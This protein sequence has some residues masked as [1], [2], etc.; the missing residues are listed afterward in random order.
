MV[1]AIE[2]AAAILFLIL[3]P[4]KG[5]NVMWGYSATRLA[6]IALALF[7]LG[8]LTFLLYWSREHENEILDRLKLS[9]SLVL[10]L[11]IIVI[12]LLAGMGIIALQG[13]W[14]RFGNIGSYIGR[15]LPL[16]FWFA[17]MAWQLQIWMILNGISTKWD[18]ET[19]VSF[20]LTA[21]VIVFVLMDAILR[22]N[23]INP[24]EFNRFSQV[25]LAPNM[26]GI[27]LLVIASFVL[28]IAGQ[29]PDKKY[30][31]LVGR[32]IT[33]FIVA[34][35]IFQF[36]G[37]VGKWYLRQPA[38]AYFP[39]L[40]D[41]FLHGKLYL[42][43]PAITMELTQKDNHWYVPYPPLNALLMMPMVALWG[44][45]HVN[46]SNYSIL[47]AALGV[48][49]VFLILEKF[50]EHGW[51]QL[52]TSAN[53]WLT[54]LFGLSTPFW[55]IAIS[56]EVWY[57]N[58]VVTV[59]FVALGTLLA[60]YE[61]SPLLI[62]LT[63]GLA[64]LARPPILLSWISLFGI[65]WQIQRD[66]NNR[67]PF[68]VWFRWSFYTAIP[69]VIIGLGFL[70]YNY[71]RFGAPFDFGYAAM[72]IGEPAR[73][74]IRT[75][76][77]FNV[78]YLSRNLEVMFLRLPHWES[79]CRFFT[80]DTEGMNMFVT[81]PA[82]IYV[83]GSFKRKEWIAGAWVSSILLIL[84][85]MLYFTTGIFQFGYRYILD[86]FIPL[87]TLIAVSVGKDKL[88]LHMKIMIL[89]GVLVNYWG[90]WWFYR[91]WCR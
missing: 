68:N 9:K 49:L 61:A 52:N 72:N 89:A 59:V 33:V 79:L 82:L 25:K 4:S 45:D 81:T 91:H 12:L 5:G 90:I 21:G 10:S 87:L 6:M 43:D 66:K 55:Q 74:D 29:N 23:G 17:L 53:I 88:P 38:E 30:F 22:E 70:W 28:G 50:S 65:F 1:N 84:P 63:L 39:Y 64:I 37:F 20:T 46:S 18:M 60:L 42:S 44:A 8:T 71:A 57:I 86:L 73:T 31:L 62:G 83:F 16:V 85:L 36:T 40:A 32:A 56:G 77:Q 48:S 35:L 75:Y 58:Q 47:F 27:F 78:R 26:P 7:V 24:S 67:V 3:N 51:T 69:I 41:S 19:F 15:G 11:A 2:G 80:A 13:N 34:W 54:A 14:L 76:G